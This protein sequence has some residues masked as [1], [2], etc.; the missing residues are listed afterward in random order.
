MGLV[1]QIVVRADDV[2]SGMLEDPRA[3]RLELALRGSHGGY[4]ECCLSTGTLYLSPRWLAILGYDV[5]DVEP[6][7]DGLIKLCHPDDAGALRA[8]LQ[9][10]MDARAH[11]DVEL[12]H[13]MLAKPGDWRWV[14]TRAVLGMPG[15]A[16]TPECLG[17]TM[18]DVS[19]RKDVE[20]ELRDHGEL[21]DEMVA[22]RTMELAETNAQ[23]QM[24]IARREKAELALQQ[25][26]EDLLTSYRA[27]GEHVRMLM[28]LVDFCR[29]IGASRLVDEVV[30]HTLGAVADLAQSKRVSIL[31]PNTAN[32]HLT[33]C[34]AV[35]V[36]AQTTDN[37]GLPIGAPIAGVVYATGQPV[38][39][40]TPD[41]LRAF[42]P[43]HDASLTGAPPFVCF[44]LDASAKILGVLTVSERVESQPFQPQERDYLELIAKI[45]ATAI[46]DILTRE[47]HDRASD[48][49]MM[50]LAKLAEHR[51]SDTGRHLDR[52]TQYCL[53]LAKE[54]R[55]QDPFRAQ[56]DDTFLHSL[57]RAV[58]LH[59]IG[60]VGIPDNILLDPGRLSDEQMAVMKQHT[61]IGARTIQT[62]I[63]HTPGVP[64]LEMAADVAQYHHE[65]WDGTGYPIGL[66]GRAIP[67]SA[68]IASVA[69]VYDALTTERVYKKAYTHDKATAI[70][71]ESSGTHFEPA[72]VDAFLRREQAFAT[73][74]KTMADDAHEHSRYAATSKSAEVS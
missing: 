58:P 3:A 20:E 35:G 4:W 6:T 51:D 31:L 9:A 61:L 56:I 44:P 72:I 59:D 73:L 17:G 33:V 15:P 25:A 49:I 41:D 23:L 34:Q 24:D 74:A 37:A 63:A 10:R 62:L 21:L 18:I 1:D 28:C 47:A 54:L 19:D 60:K 48:S 13:R 7:L 53:I 8:A 64:F 69:D 12:E 67:L 39:A 50:A 14:R 2:P 45:S 36:D 38:V 30:A 57:E 42:S 16:G 71:L 29:A 66:S 5:S 65:R 27:R 46:H 32:T 40:N 11:D 22:Q 43:A 52:V 26:N 68:R 70:I 55:A